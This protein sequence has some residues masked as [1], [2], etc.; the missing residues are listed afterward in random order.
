MD[1]N[2]LKLEELR[3]I[4]ERE[5]IRK[6]NLE[7]KAS[8]FLVVISII[9]TIISTYLSQISLSLKLDIR[10][11]ILVLSII[12]FLISIGLCILI[13]LPRNY[14]HP[15]D[16]ENFEEFE[17][18]FKIRDEEFE[19]KLYD[20]YLTSIHINHEKNEDIVK[21]LKC[22]IYSFVCFILLLILA[23]VIL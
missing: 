21:H 5:N 11:M 12:F 10:S 4:F 22:S 14:Y 23:V 17:N 19:E 13:F 9:M 15:F 16:L 7:N 18:N 1:K 2:N 6:Q 20:K 8:Y 3:L